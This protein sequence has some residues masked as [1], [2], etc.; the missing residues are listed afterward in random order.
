M[1]C[2]CKNIKTSK[3]IENLN[4]SGNS[5]TKIYFSNNKLL[6]QLELNNNMLNSIDLKKNME[7]DYIMS[8]YYIRREF[9][10]SELRLL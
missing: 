8:D 6:E 1:E 5:L 3:E 9:D 2:S 10:D 4:L 7:D